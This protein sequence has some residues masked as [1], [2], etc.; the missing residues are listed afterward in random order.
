MFTAILLAAGLAPD[1]RRPP[2]APT[3][4]AQF[5]RPG[6]VVI[7]AAGACGVAGCNCGCRSGD[8]CRCAQPAAAVTYA[9]PP[10]TYQPQPVFYPAFRPAVTFGGGCAGGG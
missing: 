5:P 4:P 2:Q 1:G 9:R 3:R 8:V 10:V 6:A 7:Q